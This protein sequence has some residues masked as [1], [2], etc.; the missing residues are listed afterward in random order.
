MPIFEYKCK[1]CNYVFEVLLGPSDAENK[2]KCEKCGSRKLEKL[3]SAPS[4]SVKGDSVTRCGLNSTCCG[5]SIPCDTPSC[6]K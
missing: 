1:K 4:I 3:I 2:L 5:S 6:K